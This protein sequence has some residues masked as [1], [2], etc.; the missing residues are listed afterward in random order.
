MTFTVA[1]NAQDQTWTEYAV[2]YT[3]PAAYAGL[4]ANVR[5][6]RDIAEG[7]ARHENADQQKTGIRCEVVQRTCTATA[8]TVEVTG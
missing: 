3:A 4:V 2:R 5:R 1:H 6:D 7:M 8:W